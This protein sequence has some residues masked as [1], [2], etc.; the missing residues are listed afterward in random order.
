V[1]SPTGAAVRD[2]FSVAK[3]RHP[4]I[5]LLLYPVAVQGIDAPAQIAAAVRDMD[6][7]GI[8]DVIII[9]RGGGSI[10]ELW[11][12]ND[13]RVVRAVA[14]SKTP[15]I[16]AVGHQTDFTLSDFAADVRA[17]TP[18]QAA[19][20]AV[21][22]LSGLLE[23][24]RSN[25]KRLVQS[26]RHVLARRRLRL[27]R[28]L[29][30]KLFQ[31]PQTLITDRMILV[32]RCRERLFDAASGIVRNAGSRW[33]LASQKLDLLNPMSVLHRG[34]ALVRTPE[35]HLVRRIRQTEPGNRLEIIVSDGQLNVVVADV[36]E[37]QGNGQEKY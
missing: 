33:L 20:L 8:A 14:A 3:R 15:I 10:E 32:D 9:G 26:L 31:I 36:K 17:A 19:E 25:E 5:P 27:E 35:G 2:V 28:C 1:T 37:R 24:L 4:G 22:D 29:S 21:P 34:Y 7:R 12:F 18:S 13:E 6:N 23:R 30:G 16:S 11:A